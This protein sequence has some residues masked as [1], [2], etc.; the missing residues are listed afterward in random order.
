MFIHTGRTGGGTK[1]VAAADPNLT[2]VSGQRL[3]DF[4]NTGD[5]ERSTGTHSRN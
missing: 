3:L 2:I 4:L 5:I 1:E